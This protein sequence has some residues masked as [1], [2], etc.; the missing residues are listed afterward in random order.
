MDKEKDILGR[1]I[2]SFAS[3]SFRDVADRDYIAARLACRARLMPQAM[4]SAQ[5]CFEKYLKYILLVNRVPAI[6]VK[7]NI[8]AALKLT[9]KLSFKV[10]ISAESREF[11]D[12][13]AEYGQFRYLD[14]S[15]FIEGPV[16]LKLDKAIWE[17]RRYAQVLDVSGKEL[18]ADEQGWLEEAKER[19]KTSADR[20]P[21]EFRLPGGVLEEILE[22]KKHPAR[23]ALIWQNGYF[24]DRK[25][26]SI[27]V[28]D[29]WD[30]SNAPLYL[31]PE[32]LDELEKFVFI[33]DW[34]A[35]AYRE[36][37]KKIQADPSKRP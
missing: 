8:A 26:K 10:E 4:W 6:K 22:S 2:N 35:K 5:Q 30:F 24:G 13:I 9:E 32:M 11:I 3:R 37:L 16:L 25:R 33:P 7:H 28:P 12:H 17:L 14:V 29:H 27:T 21:H 23:R 19:L 31:H 15:Y 34:L 1:K 20:P 36:H 18:P